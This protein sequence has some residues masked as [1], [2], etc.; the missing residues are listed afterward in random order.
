MT[1]GRDPIA[2]ATD[3]PGARTSGGSPTIAPP[4]MPKTPPH[5]P[6]ARC[7]PAVRSAL[8]IP[9][10][11][12]RTLLRQSAASKPADL[13]EKYN[14]SPVSSNS[15][16]PG[17]S[18]NVRAIMSASSMAP[19][20]APR[21]GQ[22]DDIPDATHGTARGRHLRRHARPGRH[23]AS[24]NLDQDR[25]RHFAHRPEHRRRRRHHDPQ[26]RIVGEGSECR[27]WHQARRQARPD[28]GRAV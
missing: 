20:D 22:H 6:P 16:P 26:L 25:L 18:P 10:C 19:R 5:A 24:P 28:R 11:P 15:K 21:G 1:H 12:P 13:P 7:R 4:A 9:T 3:A 23:R 14:L 8:V 17:T 27:R 2:A